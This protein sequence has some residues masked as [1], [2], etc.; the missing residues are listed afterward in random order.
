MGICRRRP[1][2]S[3]QGALLVFRCLSPCLALHTQGLSQHVWSVSYSDLTTSLQGL[4]CGKE[5][6]PTQSILFPILLPRVLASIIS[7][8]IIPELFASIILGLTRRIGPKRL[9]MLFFYSLFLLNLWN[10][11]GFS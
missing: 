10:I 3:K 11:F 2:I 1:D 7:S 9:L 6:N 8:K 5:I 4:E